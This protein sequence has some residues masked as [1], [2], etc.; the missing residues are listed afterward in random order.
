M[1]L[2]EGRSPGHWPPHVALSRLQPPS[3]P[4][5]PLPLLLPAWVTL[6]ICSRISSILERLSC[7]ICWAVDNIWSW[8]TTSH[9]ETTSPTSSPPSLPWQ[10]SWDGS[11]LVNNSDWTQPWSLITSGRTQGRQQ[12]Q[13][14]TCN[15]FPYWGKGKK[16]NKT[17]AK[18]D[19]QRVRTMCSYQV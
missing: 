10:V 16:P 9:Q 4:I 5:P 17:N 18:E 8:I 7:S 12:R 19:M 14:C 6:I 11:T 13:C 2:K 1:T 3:P 15:P